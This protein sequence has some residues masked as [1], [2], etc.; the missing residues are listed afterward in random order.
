MT[1][2][3]TPG[4]LDGTAGFSPPSDCDKDVAHGDR[5]RL[6]ELA[7]LAPDLGHPGYVFLGGDFFHLRKEA[8]QL[9]VPKIRITGIECSKILGTT[10]PNYWQ[11]AWDE[12]SKGFGKNAD[13]L[14]GINSYDGR[15][16]DQLHIHL[17][18][19]KKDIRAQL[20]K[21]DMTKL[22]IGTWNS[23]IYVLHTKDGTKD[24]TY[25]YRVAHVDNL[26]TN[27]FTLLD[28]HVATQ[29]DSG[30][31]PYNDRFAQSLA[32]AAGTNGGGYFLIAT[33]GAPSQQGQPPH[34]PDLARKPYYGGKTF[35]ALRDPNWR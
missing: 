25:V 14:L 2:S 30:G 17:T 5:K 16:E 31:H 11:G 12:A 24:D 35:E 26:K 28:D 23:N 4:G 1:D 7:K 33:Q 19:L 27:P 34:I 15:T 20:D 10:L 9:L 6:W 13:I 8:N 18:G 22:G 32:V 21:L 3:D 29:K